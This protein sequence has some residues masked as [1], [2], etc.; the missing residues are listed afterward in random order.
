M[1]AI[2]ERKEA[3]K[4]LTKRRETKE[5]DREKERKKKKTN[6]I[7]KFFPSV[8]KATFSGIL[9]KAVST[10]AATA[11]ATA[12]AAVVAAAAAREAAVAAPLI[13]TSRDRTLL[14]SLF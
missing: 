14:P 5:R 10:S 2:R 1:R 8:D 12:T 7:T 9:M 13:K 6:L 11:T 3:E 4:S